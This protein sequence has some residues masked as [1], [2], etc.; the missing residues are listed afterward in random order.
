[1]IQSLNIVSD[2]DIRV[3]NIMPFFQY[4]HKWPK[5]GDAAV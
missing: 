3:F 5:A 1:M 2:F 4:N